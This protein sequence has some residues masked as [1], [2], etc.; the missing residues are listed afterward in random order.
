MSVG[1]VPAVVNI[2]ALKKRLIAH[3]FAASTLVEGLKSNRFD[4]FVLS[5]LFSGLWVWV[6]AKT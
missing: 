4:G 2:K 5:S 1:D 3:K 6:E